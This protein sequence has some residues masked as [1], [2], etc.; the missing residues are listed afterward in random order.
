[1]PRAKRGFKARRRRNKVLK[2]AKGYY[3]G[4]SRLFRTATEAV[5]R[6]LDYAYRD[7]R[8]KK[9]SFRGIWIARINAAARLSD[10]SYSQ[11]MHGLKGAGIDLDRKVLA[12]MAVA[13]PAGFSKIVASAK[14][15]AQA[16]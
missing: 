4:R 7:R 8:Q 11:F 15:H 2:L 3:G 6:A 16:S 1:M 13:D 14:Q 5:D 12:E 10:M 9:R